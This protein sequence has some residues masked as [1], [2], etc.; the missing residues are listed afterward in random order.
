MTKRSLNDEAQITLFEMAKTW[1]QL[2]EQIEQ[3]QAVASDPGI[4]NGDAS[5][6]G[7][8]PF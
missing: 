4:L 8:Y 6:R 7:R 1:M 2:A 3:S 5:R